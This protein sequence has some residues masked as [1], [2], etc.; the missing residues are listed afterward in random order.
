MLRNIS[1][2]SYITCCLIAFTVR[3]VCARSNLTCLKRRAQI[4]ENMPPKPIIS[5]ED[6]LSAALALVK[7]EGIESV[8]ARSLAD[9]LGC[10]TKPLFRLFKNMDE[11]KQELLLRIN[12][13]CS[14]YLLEYKDFD[15]DYIGAALR[16]ISFANNEP[17][18]FKA[19]FMSGKITKTTI[20]DML[21]DNDIE[22]LLD[23]ISAT[24]EISKNDAKTVYKKMWLL[25]HGIASIMATNAGSIK[26]ED[27][28]EIL[29]D[30]YRGFVLSIHYGGKGNATSK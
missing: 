29:K 3:F 4:E 7:N 9:M 10:S 2:L 15:K 23:E 16:Y 19:L 27:A 28:E 30:A 1:F 20:S 22:K 13:Y 5:T 24:S 25:S 14:D 21:T 6:I 18:L 17:N 26:L 8:N 11:L 12:K